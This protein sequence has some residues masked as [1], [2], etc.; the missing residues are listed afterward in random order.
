MS[1]TGERSQL[2]NVESIRENVER[3]QRCNRRLEELMGCGK[4]QYSRIVIFTFFASFIG[5]TGIFQLSFTTA[6]G[7]QRC[8]LPPHIE[9]Q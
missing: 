1:G 8:S 4:F 3:N 9:K 5:S 6:E 2:Q 7:K